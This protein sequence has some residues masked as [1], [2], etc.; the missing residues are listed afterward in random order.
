MQPEDHV[1]GGFQPERDAFVFRSEDLR[2]KCSFAHDDDDGVLVPSRV[3][4]MLERAQLRGVQFR[5]IVVE[6]DSDSSPECS[7]EHVDAWWRLA[8]DITLPP[9]S[10]SM[11]VLDRHGR[12]VPRGTEGYVEIWEPPYRGVELHYLRSEIVSKEF[13]IAQTLEWSAPSPLL[14]GLVVSKKFYEICRAH[15]LKCGFVPVRIEP[16]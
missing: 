13:D 2:K 11:K 3:K 5:S 7:G 8:S 14:R 15:R 12:R 9:Y 16:G 1:E 10:P 4:A 6:N